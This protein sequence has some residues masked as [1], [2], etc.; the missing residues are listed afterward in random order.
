[1]K[2]KAQS[3]NIS[4]LGIALLTGCAS[5]GPVSVTTEHHGKVTII[6]HRS[7]VSNGSKDRIEAIDAKGVV[8]TAEIHV[9]DVGRLPDGH[10]GVIEA[11]R[12]YKVVQ[13]EHPNLNLPHHVS[14]GPK[15]VYTPPNYSPIPPDVR[16][17]DAVNE[18][19]ASKQK[20]DDAKAKIEKKL[21]EDNNLRGELQD[22]IS[23]N[24]KLNDQIRSSFH[25]DQKPPVQTPA[26]IAAQTGT[27]DLQKWGQSQSQGQQ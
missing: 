12:E 11:H 17:S 9:Y 13:S 5:T 1:M 6:H 4:L 19:N 21:A 26:E 8:T 27:S 14:S 24:Q 20:L 3:F 15:T 10:G 22:Q 16:V 7:R 2:I 18:I 25:T 23:E